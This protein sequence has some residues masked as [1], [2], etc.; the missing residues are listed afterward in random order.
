MLLSAQ[1]ARADGVPEYPVLAMLSVEIVGTAPTPGLGVDRSH[2][3]YEVQ[4]ANARSIAQ[5]PGESLSA[6]MARNLTG[7]NIN[8]ISGSPFQSDITYRGFRLS[9]VLGTSQGISVYLDGVRVNEPFGDVVNWDMLPEAAIANVLLAP[10]SNPLYGLNTLGG[11][12]ALT[13][14][15]GRSHPGFEAGASDSSSGQ[16][17]SD[18]A[19]GYDSGGYWHAFAAATLFKDRGWRDQSDGRLGNLYAKAGGGDG[20]RDWTLALLAGSSRLVGNGL[21]PSTSAAGSAGSANG[22]DAGNAGDGPGG[23]GQGA[24][25]EANRRAVYTAPDQSR[26]RLRQL[27]FTLQQRLGEHAELAAGAYGRNSRRDTVNGDVGD[28]YAD[29]VATCA[30][31]FLP[32]GQPANGDACGYTRD[33]GRALHNASFNTSSTRQQ[34]RGANLTLSADLTAHQLLAGASYDRSSVSYVQFQQDAFFAPGRS[35]A[36]DPDAEREEESAV[37]G[38]SRTLGLYA[39]DTW[40]VAEGVF[41]T[42]SA[43]YNHAR[44]S[45]ILS[46]GGEPQPQERFSY[47]KLNPALG[48]AYR[49]PGGSGVTLFANVAQNNRVPTVIEL[50]CA[51]RD[52][53]CR[54]PVGLQSDPYLKQVVSRTAEAGARWQ[55]GAG[56]SVSL[57]LYRTVNQDDIL[58]LSSGATQQ[59][60]FTNVARTRHQGVDLGARRQAGALTAHI[61]YSYLD[62]AYDAAGTLFTGSRNVQVVP[63][64]R[65]AGLPRHTFKLGLDW[66]ACA[67]LTLGAD[68]SAVSDMASQGNEDGLRA[69]TQPGSTP[70]YADWR[71]RGHALLGLHA[72]YQVRGWELYARVNNAAN[73]RYETYGALATDMFPNGQLLQ[74]ADGPVQPALARFVAPGAPRSVVAGLR[75]RF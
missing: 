65:L 7:V 46:S 19:Y 22:A 64:T 55:G 35:V 50:G 33:Q 4:T 45:N 59:G 44:V 53:P 60:Y 13:T 69:D 26:N 42:A 20:M 63:G 43:R 21:L 27:S 49:L 5:A 36:A 51:D 24:L 67:A 17:R 68:I 62:A 30:G 37:S 41:L 10:G 70:Q 34:S 2:L 54:L 48:I 40:T 52:H 38:S 75:F 71:I 72:S 16:R 25:Y 1:K 31:G 29:Y 66:K 9:P 58:F 39:A 12:L 56:G 11:A 61:S 6:W 18:L 8:E 14:K 15:S 32:D 47:S 28:S 57:S 23:G 3:P 74:P 73:R